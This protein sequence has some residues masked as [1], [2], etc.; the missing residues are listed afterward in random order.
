[1]QCSNT[2]PGLASGLQDEI[3]PS[4]RGVNLEDRMNL[5]VLLDY[6]NLD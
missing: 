1:M 5:T 3:D 6:S 4:A 2:G